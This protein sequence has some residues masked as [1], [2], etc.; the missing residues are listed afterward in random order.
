[1][2]KQS[3]GLVSIIVVTIGKEG[4]LRSCLDSI[5]RQSYKNREVIIIDDS[6]S[7]SVAKQI[8]KDYPNCRIFSSPKKLFYSGGLNK[9]IEM[10]RGEFT[11]CLN[12]DVVLDEKFIEYAL[13]GFLVDKKIGMVNGKILRND[14]RTLDSAGLSLSYCRTAVERGYGYKDKGQF[15]KEGHIFGVNGA[16]AFYSRS[17]LEDIKQEGCY[18]DHDF[19]FFY[20]DLDVAWRANR[21]GWRGYYIPKAKAY[22]FRGASVR[23]A[24]GLGKPFARR[25]INDNLYV[26]LIKNRYLTIAK[27]ESSLDFFLHLPGIMLY[28]FLTLSHILLFRPRIMKQLFL[29]LG[30]FKDALSKRRTFNKKFNGNYH[31][32]S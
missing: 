5:D 1:M 2:D 26:D 30:Y 10:S 27:N 19:H 13:R 6:L 15:E 11:L 16:V 4:Y 32:F 7:D 12:D 18:F 31:A 21:M 22:H 8:K 9:G 3:N 28:D 20:E 24:Q 14:T 17:M 25:F 29:S 23:S